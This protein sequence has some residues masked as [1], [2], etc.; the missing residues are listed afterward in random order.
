M[1]RN[2]KGCNAI[3]VGTNSYSTHELHTT[4]YRTLEEWKNSLC[5]KFWNILRLAELTSFSVKRYYLSARSDFN[6]ILRCCAQ[7]SAAR[8]IRPSILLPASLN[9]KET[10]VRPRFYCALS[11]TI[12]KLG[13]HLNDS[14][15]LPS[16]SFLPAYRSL[17]SFYK[18]VGWTT[19]REN[20]IKFFWC[21]V[22]HE[23]FEYQLNTVI[24]FWWQQ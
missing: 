22:H 14:T 23:M 19:L 4:R 16:P 24:H 3:L 8:Q 10:P 1:K 7:L 15:F 5:W 18:N 6:S 13:G 9:A 2:Q 20:K 12:H 21:S 11:L 17:L